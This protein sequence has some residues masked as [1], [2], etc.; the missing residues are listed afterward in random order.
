MRFFVSDD[1][2]NYSLIFNTVSEAEKCFEEWK[3]DAM[4]EG[5][6]LDD[7]YIELHQ[8]EVD[9]EDAIV[10]KRV[11]PEVDLEKNKELGTPEENE[12]D[13]QFWAKWKEVNV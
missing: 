3:D 7:S 9:E 12:M 10:I 11:V 2:G 1:K 8:F 13:F 5:V 4:S 6:T